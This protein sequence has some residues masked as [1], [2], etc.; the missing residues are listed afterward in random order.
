MR[1]S[2]GGGFGDALDRDPAQVAEDVA[3][4]RF[5]AD[6][7]ERIYGTVLEADGSVDAAAT[8]TRRHDIRQE[9][10]TRA[11]PAQRPQGERQAPAGEAEVFPLYPGVVQQGNLAYAED[12][13]Q[14]LA[15]S[16]HHWTDGCPVLEER[17]W[18]EGG[19][20]VVFRTYLDPQ[21]GRALHVEVA[22]ADGPRS[23]AV[24]PRRWTDVA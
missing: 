4:G 3:A 10:L 24:N 18:P 16:P 15:E 19:P 17:R 11:K 9:R 22:L 5:P 2:S 13:G 1:L 20:D 6:D 8:A 7:A 14:V 23:F 21:T 12:S